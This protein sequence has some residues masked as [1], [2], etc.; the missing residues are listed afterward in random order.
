MLA[1]V[2]GRLPVAPPQIQGVAAAV[3]PRDDRGGEDVAGCVAQDV[4]VPARREPHE[5][6]RSGR[7]RVEVLLRVLDTL[8]EWAWGGTVQD[9]NAAPRT[10][11]DLDPIETWGFFM[12][13]G[14]DGPYLSG[15]QG[16]ATDLVL[17]L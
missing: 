11:V 15:R 10:F 8:G 7:P 3:E 16:I 13:T 6:R 9:A 5:R 2:E 14:T 17:A 12:P 1:H 4:A